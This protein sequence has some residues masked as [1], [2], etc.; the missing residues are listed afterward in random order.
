MVTFK[1]VVL[2]SGDFVSG[3]YKKTNRLIKIPK[4]STKMK[5][6]CQGKYIDNTPPI[7]GAKAGDNETKGTKIAKDLCAFNGSKTSESKDL[8]TTI[9]AEADIAWKNRHN[10][11]NSIF[12]ALIQPNVDNKNSGIVI[13]KIVFLPNRSDNKPWGI[14]AMASPTIKTV[15]DIWVKFFEVLK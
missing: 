9:Q 1:F 7:E 14:W 13:F 11:K 8:P 3:K 12:L 4:M 5:L 6:D 15:K 10:I 2:F